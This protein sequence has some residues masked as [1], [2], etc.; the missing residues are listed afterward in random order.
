MK[1]LPLYKDT[2]KVMMVSRSIL[3][4]QEPYQKPS[5]KT[6]QK[7]NKVIFLILTVKG[8]APYRSNLQKNFKARVSNL[9]TIE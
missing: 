9:M 4:C 2:Q 6:R 5:P 1:S 8:S 3:N 7:K